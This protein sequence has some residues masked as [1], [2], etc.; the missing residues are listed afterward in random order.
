MFLLLTTLILSTT[1]K[2]YHRPSTMFSIH[3]FYMNSQKI[4]HLGAVI[5]WSASR[6]CD[7]ELWLAVR[8]RRQS[9]YHTV[10]WLL[11]EQIYFNTVFWKHQ[12]T[13]NNVLRTICSRGRMTCTGAGASPSHHILSDIISWYYRTKPGKNIVPGAFS[14]R[15]CEQ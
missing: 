3:Q 7:G 9:L 5:G 14:Q 13:C 12:T 2:V 8:R 11:N 15:G 10:K 4:Q 6:G 1:S